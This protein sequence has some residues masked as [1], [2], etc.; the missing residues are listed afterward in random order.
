MP[1]ATP[2]TSGSNRKPAANPLLSGR[3][4]RAT[5]P[6][7]AL[8]SVDEAPRK[9]PEKLASPTS[10]G[11]RNRW[12]G[13]C[14]PARGARLTSGRS[15]GGSVGYR[16]AWASVRAKVLVDGLCICSRM[17]AALLNGGSSRR[18]PQKPATDT[19]CATNLRVHGPKV[20]PVKRHHPAALLLL[21]NPGSI[22]ERFS[23]PSAATHRQ[24][25]C[26][27]A[28][29]WRARRHSVVGVDDAQGSFQAVTLV[30]APL[31]VVL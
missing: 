21:K 7:H 20:W 4:R 29:R 16:A 31:F 17:G 1:C 9:T 19:P 18:R 8:R 10:A 2:C 28:P 23:R 12:S 25:R 5:L 3:S 14:T 27:T 6:W 15:G 13:A 30:P 11:T 24:E 26:S 22:H